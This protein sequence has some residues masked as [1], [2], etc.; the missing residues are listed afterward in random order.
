MNAEHPDHPG[1]S[2]DAFDDGWTCRPDSSTPCVLC[3]RP[4]WCLDPDGDPRH[5]VLCL[6]TTVRSAA[7]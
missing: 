5:R 4:A 3:G 7:A 2:A 1:W 6:D